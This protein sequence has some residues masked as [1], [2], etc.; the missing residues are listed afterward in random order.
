MG[1]HING[2][3]KEIMYVFILIFILGI[4]CTYYEFHTLTQ[5]ANVKQLFYP[6]VTQDH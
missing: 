4:P 2:S 5:N 1:H 6:Q 3:R